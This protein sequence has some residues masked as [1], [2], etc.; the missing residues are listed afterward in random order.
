M[1]LWCMSVY[2]LPKNLLKIFKNSFQSLSSK[3]A[4]EK[5]LY[6]LK[7]FLKPKFLDK[8]NLEKKI[9]KKR[10]QENI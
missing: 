6:P 7:I 1:T 3:R 8:N 2:K 10:F 5:D 4:G 9:L